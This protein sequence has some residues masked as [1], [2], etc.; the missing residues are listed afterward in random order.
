[1]AIFARYPGWAIYSQTWEGATILNIGR[2]MDNR[3][4]MS[5]L[6]IEK[7]LLEIERLLGNRK[8]YHDFSFIIKDIKCFRLRKLFNYLYI[9][10]R[11]I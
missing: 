5:I 9:N 11:K 4:E 2:H 6:K 8:T 10:S 3:N 7:Y 1:M